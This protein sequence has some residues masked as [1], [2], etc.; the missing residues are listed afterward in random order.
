[1]PNYNRIVSF[2]W[3]EVIYHIADLFSKII[4]TICWKASI[5]MNN[6]I[7]YLLMKYSYVM[8]TSSVLCDSFF[9]EN[10][11]NLETLSFSAGW[12]VGEQMQGSGDPSDRGLDHHQRIGWRLRD[13]TV[14]CGWTA[15]RHDLNW[16]C[17]F[18]HQGKKVAAYDRPSGPGWWK[19]SKYFRLRSNPVS[20]LPAIYHSTPSIWNT[21]ILNRSALFDLGQP[22]DPKPRSKE[23]SQSDQVDR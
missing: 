18:G 12:H 22:L 4:L 21:I 5:Q 11:K 13:Q 17:N 1:M 10:D 19:F 15:E 14:E 2:V 20:S 3:I 16:K 9:L 6:D 8:W 23:R 7:W